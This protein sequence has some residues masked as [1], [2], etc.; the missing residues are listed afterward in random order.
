MHQ[1]TILNQMRE[2]LLHSG[3]DGKL[4]PFLHVPS[5]RHLSKQLVALLRHLKFRD[6]QLDRRRRVSFLKEREV[7]I[8]PRAAS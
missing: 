7:A 5:S 6:P 4:I 2:A 8:P 3:D 1:F